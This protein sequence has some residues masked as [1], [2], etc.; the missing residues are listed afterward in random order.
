MKQLGIYMLRWQGSTPILALV[1]WVLG[2]YFEI[3]NFIG[4][5]IIANL[6]GSLIFYK[7]DKLIFKQKQQ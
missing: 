3:D 5:A 6:I 1:P 4:V 2:K 7:I